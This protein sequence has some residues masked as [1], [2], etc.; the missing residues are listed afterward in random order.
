MAEKDWSS[1]F[2]PDDQYVQA[3]YTNPILTGIVP[4]VL[5]FVV[6]LLYAVGILHTYW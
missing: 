1:S 3:W 5:T 6:Y 2:G 4:L